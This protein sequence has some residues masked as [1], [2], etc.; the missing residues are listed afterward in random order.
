MNL[1]L[2][3]VKTPFILNDEFTILNEWDNF[4]RL[5]KMAA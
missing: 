2:N 1:N 4:S 3:I 5:L